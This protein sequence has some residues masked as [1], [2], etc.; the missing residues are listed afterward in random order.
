MLCSS[1][2][3]YTVGINAKGFCES[4]WSLKGG[5]LTDFIFP[6]ISADVEVAPREM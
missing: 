3:L 4:K 1:G 6:D 2:R 5:R